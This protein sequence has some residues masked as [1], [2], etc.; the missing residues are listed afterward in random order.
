MKRRSFFGSAIAG[1]SIAATST[2]HAKRAPFRRKSPSSM[3]LIE[4]GVVCT[5]GYNHMKQIWNLYMNPPVGKEA[6]G[7]YWPRSTGMVA[8]HCWDPDP[9]DAVEWGRDNDAK[10]VDN[11]YDMLDKVDAVI[12]ADYSACGWFPQLTKPYLEAGLP[13]LINRPFAL[14]MKDAKEMIARSKEFDTPIFVPSAFESR[15]EVVRQKNDLKQLRED[16]AIIHGA[17]QSNVSHEFMAH[18]CH[19]VYNVHEVLE[20]DVMS[21]GF[22]TDGDWREYNTAMLTMRC[23]QAGGHDYFV[24]IKM[25]GDYRSRGSLTVI[26][27]KGRLYEHYG[28]PGGGYETLRVHQYPG[29]FLFNRMIEN[30]EMPQTHEHILAKTKTM[31]TGIYSNQEKNGQMVDIAELPETWR[32][33]DWNPE[34]MTNVEFL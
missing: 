22:Q 34:R 13:C 32:A 14:S 1:A 17:F 6:R 26:T 29:L 15:M 12:F 24:A 11:Y 7:G 2:A 5:G 4:I 21:V 25:G 8:T 19:G 9:D 31:L 10:V 27:D 3:E 33:P 16:G 30:R 20:P 28:N 23:G 18:G